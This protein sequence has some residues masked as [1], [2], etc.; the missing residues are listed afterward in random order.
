ME[1]I[2]IH[3]PAKGATQRKH[4]KVSVRIFQ[5]TL[6]RRE[7]RASYETRTSGRCYFNP[8][9]REGSDS[10]LCGG[11]LLFD[12][13]F[14]PRSREG[15]DVRRFFRLD[16]TELFQSTLPRRE[17]P[18]RCERKQRRW[19]F[20][21]TLPRRERRR[22]MQSRAADGDF[23]PRSREG[24]DIFTLPRRERH[25]STTS[26]YPFGYFNPRSREGSD[27]RVTQTADEWEV[28]FQS[29][30]PRRERLERKLHNKQTDIISIHAPA[31]G[32][33]SRPTSISSTAAFQSTLPRRER[34]ITSSFSSHRARFQSTLPRR[35]RPLARPRLAVR[36]VISIHAPAKGA[37]VQ[38]HRGGH[39]IPISIHAPAKGA[40]LRR[41]GADIYTIQF[42][43][44]LP[45]RERH[46]ILY[47]CG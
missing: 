18:S 22:S 39:G 41:H 14:N 38:P 5:S 7:R 29:T 47:A 28:L 44:T 34:R 21:S 31:K 16:R 37:T 43:S 24:S 36:T 26:K 1:G 27:A 4:L 15:S 45:R 35:E 42:Q 40:T 17:R 13:Y 46:K 32:A 33:T 8:R 25:I 10:T 6:P 3:A 12:L 30:L 11:N 19:K 20:Q 9:S 23:N 2:S